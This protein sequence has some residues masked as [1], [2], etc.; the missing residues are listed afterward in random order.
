D[1]LA[2][3]AQPLRYHRSVDLSTPSASGIRR[4]IP[5]RLGTLPVGAKFKFPRAPRLVAGA[6]QVTRHFTGG[7]AYKQQQQRGEDVA[8][9]CRAMACARL[10]EDTPQA[11]RWNERSCRAVREPSRHRPATGTGAG[12]NPSGVEAQLDRR[13]DR[14]VVQV[15]GPGGRLETQLKTPGAQVPVQ[16]TLRF[17]HGFKGV[18][19]LQKE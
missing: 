4:L 15:K 2:V 6:Q 13:R 18:A 19:I 11:H 8:G 16:D 7:V 3:P 14:G 1:L 9:Q 17:E 5:L 12:K 10:R